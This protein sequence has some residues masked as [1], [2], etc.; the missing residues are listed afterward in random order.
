MGRA[1]LFHCRVISWGFVSRLVAS[2]N[3]CRRKIRPIVRLSV[4]FSSVDGLDALYDC[5]VVRAGRQNIPRNI[6]F[7]ILTLGINAS[8]MSRRDNVRAYSICARI[9][10]RDPRPSAEV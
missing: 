2:P 3:S 6:F 9:Q 10:S 5:F 1:S 8:F 7:N 4:P